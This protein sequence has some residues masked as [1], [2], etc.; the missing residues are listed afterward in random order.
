M[1]TF[2]GIDISKST[3]DVCLLRGDTQLFFAVPNT[4]SGLKRLCKKIKAEDKIGCILFEP[5]GGFEKAAARYLSE[6]DLPLH[7]VNPYT[8]KSFSRS[9]SACKNDRKDAY[10]LSLYGQRMRPKPNCV[11]DEQQEYLK[12]CLQRREDLSTQLGCEKRRFKQSKA[13]IVTKSIR[14]LMNMLEKE[15]VQLDQE[16]QT[17]LSASPSLKKNIDI[18]KSIPG[19]GCVLAAKFAGFLPELWQK[20]ISPGGLVALAGI[21]PYDRDS[22]QKRG[23]RFIRGGRRIPRDALYIAVLTGKH[24]IKYIHDCYERL[25]KKNKPKKVAIVACMRRLLLLAHKLIAQQRMFSIEKG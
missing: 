7:Q 13:D 4:Q 5:T 1:E 16:I 6:E 15:I 3:L 2:V 24:K 22:G 18:L 12:A 25:I 20:D 19:I 9:V 10:A 8:F 17:I 14:S 11:Y 21:A 23:K